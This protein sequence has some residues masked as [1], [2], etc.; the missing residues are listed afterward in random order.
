MKGYLGMPERT[1][2]VYKD[3]WYE[4]GDVVRIDEEGFVW[5]VGRLS[6]FSKIGGEMVPH[7]S[8]E[9][10]LHDLAG[11]TEQTFAVAGIPD[12]K[13]GEKLA[14]LCLKDIDVV[15]L[16]EELKKSDLPNLWIPDAQFFFIV[17]A[18]PMLGT[19]KV[20]LGKV[21]HIAKEAFEK[22]E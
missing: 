16:V 7:G 5:I 3:G 17:Y 22:E 10:K 18:I 9:E 19:G 11:V 2:D 8:V 13:K 15:S 12:E 20:D 1:A 6:R 4:T 14:V 21:K